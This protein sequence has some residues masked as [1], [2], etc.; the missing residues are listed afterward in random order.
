M[1]TLSTGCETVKIKQE[2]RHIPKDSVSDLTLRHGEM[3][4]W[5][6]RGNVETRVTSHETCNKRKSNRKLKPRN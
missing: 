3:T 1:K 2:P 5:G 6:D 4:N